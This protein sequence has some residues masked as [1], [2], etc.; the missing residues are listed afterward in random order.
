MK[1]WK[2][3]LVLP[4]IFWFCFAGIQKYHVVIIEKKK[5]LVAAGQAYSD[6]FSAGD[7]SAWIENRAVDWVLDDP[8]D[9]VDGIR[10]AE[11]MLLYNSATDDVTQYAKIK[12]V[13][14]AK[15]GV[16]LRYVDGVSSY[17]LVYITSTPELVWTRWDWTG[18]NDPDYKETIQ[19]DGG[20]LAGD[21]GAGDTIAVTVQG[22]SN[23]TVVK[24]WRNPTNNTPFSKDF[25]D[26]G[27]DAA[28]LTFQDNPP[29][30]CNTGT[31]TGIGAYGANTFDDFFAGDV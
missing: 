9:N 11:Q 16:C 12:L 21:F 2:L 30:P 25:W 28:D 13:A 5:A 4:V 27:A 15:G 1:N 19:N 14:N 24:I 26:N 3:L 29:T 23:Q 10:V 22:T 8:S 6:D 18:A 20:A 17:Y 31:Y 7:L